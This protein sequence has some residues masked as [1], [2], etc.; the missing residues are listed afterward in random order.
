MGHR[1]FIFVGSLLFTFC[2]VFLTRLAA[3]E[4]C[5][6]SLLKNTASP[7]G[8]KDRGGRC[9]GLYIN[10]VGATT[11]L[12]VSFTESFAS[13]NLQTDSSLRVTWDP[14]PGNGGFRIRAQGIRRRL[15]YRMDTYQPPL[16]RSFTWPLAILSSLN[17]LRSDLGVVGTVQVMVGQ[18]LRDVY[19]P[20]RILQHGESK[21]IPSYVLGLLPGVELTEVYI[22]LSKVGS[23]GQPAKLI[24]DGEKLGYG[25]YPSERSIDIPVTGLTETGIYYME[26]GATLKNGGTTTVSCWFYN[27]D[28]WE[29]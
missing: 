11:L 22:S 25:Y 2:P 14:P 18:T 21:H 27:P 4:N 3:Q 26:I 5:D 9:E 28:R 1:L 24:R 7:L 19:I 8:Y 13:F 17:I 16:K 23:D 12:V 10:Q 20:L 6:P 15:Y 29:K